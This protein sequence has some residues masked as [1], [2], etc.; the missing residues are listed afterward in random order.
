MDEERTQ[1]R[2]EVIKQYDLEHPKQ[3]G[4]IGIYG[5]EQRKEMGYFLYYIFKCDKYLVMPNKTAEYFAEKYKID[6]HTLS[7]GD[8]WYHEYKSYIQ[9]HGYLKLSD[10]RMKTNLSKTKG[11]ASY[12]LLVSKEKGFVKFDKF[13]SLYSYIKDEKIRF[14]DA[15]LYLSNGYKIWIDFTKIYKWMYMKING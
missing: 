14:Y 2:K 3:Q 9:N 4:Y 12:F 5:A 6:L 11:K 10:F 15:Y 1:K 8:L 13:K 7:T